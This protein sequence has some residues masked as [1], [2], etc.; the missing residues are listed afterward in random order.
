[1]S[2]SRTLQVQEMEGVL[3]LPNTKTTV[4]PSVEVFEVSKDAQ[5][6]VYTAR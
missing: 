1:M 6:Q 4:L 3:E 5:K 2:L